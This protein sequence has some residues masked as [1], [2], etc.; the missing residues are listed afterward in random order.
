M[1]DISYDEMHTLPGIVL[2]NSDDIACLSVRHR[3][4]ITFLQ[5]T[6]HIPL[7]IVD[8][9]A[10]EILMLCIDKEIKDAGNKDMMT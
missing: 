7:Y 1:D 4:G 2:Y 3:N 6:E 5:M 8:I 9:H 10:H